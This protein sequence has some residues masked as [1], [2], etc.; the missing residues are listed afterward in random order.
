MDKQKSYKH[1][2]YLLTHYVPVTPKGGGTVVWDK[3]TEYREIVLPGDVDDPCYYLQRLGSD[4]CTD[5]LEYS[6]FSELTEE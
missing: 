3:H 4:N 6:F 1:W 5:L 2:S